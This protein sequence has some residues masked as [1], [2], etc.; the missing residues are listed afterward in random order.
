MNVTIKQKIFIGLPVNVIV[1]SLITANT[2]TTKKINK[3]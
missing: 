3:M 2:V 1:D